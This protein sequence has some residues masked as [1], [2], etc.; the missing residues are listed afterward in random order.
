MSELPAAPGSYVPGSTTVWNN[1]WRQIYE[2]FGPAILA[3]A[4]RGG[5]NEHSAEDVL[6]EVMTTVIRCQHTGAGGYDPG[7][8]PF[9]AWLWGI[10]RN[11]V[12][13][14]RREDK[15]EIPASEISDVR[16]S[17]AKA[18]CST[19]FAALDEF[20]QTEE[21]QWKRALLAAAMH[22]MKQRVTSRNF[23]IYKELLNET[24]NASALAERHNMEA[25][26]VYAVKHRCEE[27]LLAEARALLRLWEDMAQPRGK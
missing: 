15:K 9:G 1:A 4:R 21:G 11:R 20:E 13:S 27:I 23:S 6:Q 7:R 2:Q 24:S 26:A 19:T 3:Y 12:R 16:C 25:N 14:V 22:R 10:I 17:E 8:G 18:G 5:L